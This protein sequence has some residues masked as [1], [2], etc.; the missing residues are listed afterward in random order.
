MTPIRVK[1]GNLVEAPPR[2]TSLDSDFSAGLAQSCVLFDDSVP[3]AYCLVD[4]VVGPLER[5]ILHRRTRTTGRGNVPRQ[6][7]SVDSG[8]RSQEREKSGVCIG[9]TFC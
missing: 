1:V 2:G 9:K 6:T 7:M 3:L 4:V 8:K 5:T